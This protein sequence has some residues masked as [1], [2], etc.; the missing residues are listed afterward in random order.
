MADTIQR[1]LRMSS[2]PDDVNSVHGH[3]ESIWAHS[4][5]ISAVDRLSFELALI[6]LAG[7]VICHADSGSGVSFTLTIE[8]FADSI[9]AT[10]RDT[11]EPVDV[12]LTGRDM[13]GELSESG[14]GIPLIT[15]LVDEFAYDREGDLNHWRITRKL[16]P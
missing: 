15:A 10:V 3:L 5:A 7:N 2:P 14:R 4:P 12:E 11:G 9:Q 16:L 8:T 1:T 6:E 13:P